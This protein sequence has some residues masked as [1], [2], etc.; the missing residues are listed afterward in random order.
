MF[1]STSTSIFGRVHTSGCNVNGRI[2]IGLH[3]CGGRYG[4][5]YVQS[6]NKNMDHGLEL[7]HNS[8]H[9]GLHES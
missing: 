4:G 7:G 2:D 6:A 8:S 5:A 3:V 1:S 9:E